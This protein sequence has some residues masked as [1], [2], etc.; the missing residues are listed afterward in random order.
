VTVSERLRDAIEVRR[1]ARLLCTGSEVAAA[2]ERMAAS[3]AAAVSG[4]NPI[5]IAIMQGGMYAALELCRRFDFPYELDYVHLSR[6][7]SS[8]TGG[9]LDWTRGP[10]D[11]CRGRVVVL[12]DDILDRGE[13]L[14]AAQAAF[15]ALPVDRLHTAVLVAKRAGGTGP[16]PCVDSVGFEIDDHFVFGSG[17]DYRG[18]W[19]GLPGLYAVA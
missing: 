11:D 10:T 3:V 1:R 15:R 13:T 8:T 12:V 6:Y 18:Y 9:R 14:V 17:M 2:L 19:R 16:S 5:V 4:S 7:G